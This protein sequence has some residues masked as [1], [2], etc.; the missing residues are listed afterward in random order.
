MPGHVPGIH[1]GHA[2]TALLAFASYAG[3]I[4][5]CID[6]PFDKAR[7]ARDKRGHDERGASRFDLMLQYLE[8][9]QYRLKDLLHFRPSVYYRLFE[10]YN[11]D[12]F[13]AQVAALGAGLAILLLLLRGGGDARQGRIVAAILAACWL[14]IAWAFHYQRL[15]TI[16][17]GGPL[18]AAG[19]AL[20]GMLLLWVAIAR[21]GLAFNVSRRASD[22]AGLAIFLFAVA[23][24]PL[25]GPLAGR[26]WSQAELFGLAPDPTAV[27]TLGLVLLARGRAARLL[28]ALPV[29]WCIVQ[30]TTLWLLRS[31]DAL[32]LPGAALLALAVA[33][34][35]G[36]TGT[37]RLPGR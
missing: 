29:V 4:R 25:I 28:L 36:G 24:Q 14:W 18:I 17:L 11:A 27:A 7:E 16:H 30:G 21:G 13:P 37:A 31:P 12:V 23:V 1:V 35:R 9:F 6:V 26:P 15:A 3:A 5:R 10:L 2:P 22:L 32:V 33:F 19:F 8:Y 34:R 20:Q